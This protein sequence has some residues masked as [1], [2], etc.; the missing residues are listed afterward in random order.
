MLSVF[1]RNPPPP[2]EPLRDHSPADWDLLIQQASAQ[3]LLPALA[4][5][6]QTLAIDSALPPNILELCQIAETLNAERNRTILAE[7]VHVATLL[8]Q[9]GLQPVALK[10]LAYL[11]TGVYPNPALRYLSDIDLL[12]P[13]SEIP[14]SIAHLRHH[15]YFEDEGNRFIQFRH[16]Y[17]AI[18]RPGLPHIEIH[19]RLG[20]GVCD[21]L[22]PAKAI[23]ADATSIAQDGAT[24][25][26]PSPTHLATHLILHSQLAHPY[27]NRIFTPLRALVDL[28]HLQARFADGISWLCIAKTYLDA[29]ESATLA[30]HL[31]HAHDVLGFQIPRMGSFL[32]NV[33]ATLAGEGSFRNSGQSAPEMA[34]FRN[35]A[36]GRLGLYGKFRWYRRSLLYRY[37]TLRFVDPIYWTLSLFSRRLRLL[38][39]IL[40]DPSSWPQVLREVTRLDFYRSLFA[41]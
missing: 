27:S 23:L 12:L 5:R 29:G 3:F 2:R 21:R 4:S 22:L 30:L 32:Q 31:K 25:L 16:H 11:L 41:L 17:P 9:I 34:L 24:F 19:H 18:R 8:N 33:P 14:R 40:L 13:V 10:G 35:L 15:G 39:Q 37:P 6:F 38:P 1:F 36:T 26:I 7:A 28:A 20:Q